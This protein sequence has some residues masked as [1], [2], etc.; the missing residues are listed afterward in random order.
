MILC[1]MFNVLPTYVGMW[2]IGTR[3]T[4][5]TQIFTKAHI[6]YTL[7]YYPCVILNHSSLVRF[8]GCTINYYSII[9]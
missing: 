1:L 5:I 9:H 3:H 6:G 8:W 7:R 2:H 4:D